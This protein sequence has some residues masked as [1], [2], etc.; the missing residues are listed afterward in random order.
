MVISGVIVILEEAQNGHVTQ[1]MGGIVKMV[2]NWKVLSFVAYRAQM[3]YKAV[4]E[5]PLGLTDIEEATSGAAE[6]MLGLT[7]VEEATSEAADFK[8]GLMDQ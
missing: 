3:L 2:G 4:S 7:N 8:L 1:G 6:S 5:S